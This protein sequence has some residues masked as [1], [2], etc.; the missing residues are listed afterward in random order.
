MDINIL[1]IVI[2]VINI[3]VLFI[4]LRLLV[5]KPVSKFMKDRKKRI[6]DEIENAAKTK[7]DA[8]SLKEEFTK[9]LSESEKA[10]NEQMVNII[11]QANTEAE[12]I[13]EAAHADAEKI[14]NDAHKKAEADAA[15]VL[16]G[17]KDDIKDLSLKIASKI[18]E[19]EVNETDNKTLVENIFKEEH[20]S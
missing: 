11:A 20:I 10:A 2:H 15:A 16:S 19:R 6:T 8:L 7:E 17:I 1:D 5:Y 4:I 13:T 9:K 12:R 3:F 14:T 18:L